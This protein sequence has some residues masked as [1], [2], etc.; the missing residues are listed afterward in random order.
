MVAD[1]DWGSTIAIPFLLSTVRNVANQPPVGRAKMPNAIF[2]FGDKVKNTPS[3]KSVTRNGE[4]P[5][6]DTPSSAYLMGSE[7][8]RHAPSVISGF[9]PWGCVKMVF[10]NGPLLVKTCGPLLLRCWRMAGECV[11][12]A[13][14][15]GNTNCSHLMQLAQ[16]VKP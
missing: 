2:F 13:T 12:P 10:G 15:L 8:T 11:L 5:V 1:E 3:T 16:N 4:F 14:K 7:S 6:C 9:T